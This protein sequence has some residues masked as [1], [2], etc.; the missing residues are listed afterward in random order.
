MRPL[1]IIHLPGWSLKKE[2]N[3]KR[4]RELFLKNCFT[5]SG[6]SLQGYFPGSR[7]PQ[8]TGLFSALMPQRSKLKNKSLKI[9]GQ[10][11]GSTPKDKEKEKNQLPK[12]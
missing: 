7:N 12:H 3:T 9:P 1:R 11:S 10:I 6:D 4:S 8:N 5:S 2:L